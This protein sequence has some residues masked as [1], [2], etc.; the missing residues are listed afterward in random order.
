M[1]Q[2]LSSTGQPL[3]I[4]AQRDLLRGRFGSTYPERSDAWVREETAW[5]HEEREYIED[6]SSWLTDQL[7][8][9]HY[10]RNHPGIN[11]Q[12]M[13]LALRQ[14]QVTIASRRPPTPQ[15]PPPPP[16]PLP[17]TGM[18]TAIMDLVEPSRP[19]QPPAPPVPARPPV[20]RPPVPG[21]VTMQSPPPQ[22]SVPSVPTSPPVSQQAGGQN[23]T[24]VVVA[25]VGA[26]ALAAGIA[27]WAS[28]RD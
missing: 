15:P 11:L 24:V 16:L 19:P 27:W 17:D 23:R 20:P 12:Y 28:S 3:S 21:N 2:P 1:G 5:H 22:P 9:D 18:R 25:A 4:A 14:R 6:R 7:V 8:L 26:V 13:N 10:R